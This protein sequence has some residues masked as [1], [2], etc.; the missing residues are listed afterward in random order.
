MG[1]T[2]DLIIVTKDELATLDP[3]SSDSFIRK[4]H[5]E[6]SLL[7][8]GLSDLGFNVAR[9]SWSDPEF[10]WSSTKAI[11]FRSTWD[12]FHRYDEWIDWLAKTGEVTTMINPHAI[13]EWNMDKHYLIDLK[14]KGIHIPDTIVFETGSVVNL[15]EAF[16][17]SGWTN[18]ILKPCIAGTARHTYKIVD[19]V[20]PEL[21][22]TF[23]ELI[24]KEAM[25]L[26]PFINSVVTK[27]E[28]SLMVMGGQYTH[29]VIKKPKD[30]DFRVQDDFGG[31]VEIYEPS[32]EEI[33]FAEHVVATCDPQPTYARVDVV[34]DNK[35]KLAL[36]ELELIEPEV[37]FRLFP[38]AANVLVEAVAKKLA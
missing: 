7:A 9:K 38:D 2:F 15:A 5:R 33:A 24:K 10:D 11:L 17:S 12:Y 1:K 4:V 6:E 36:M 13:I 37:W 27:G 8:D 3:D 26:Q 32:P 34:T 19:G 18:A 22:A 28:I 31:S 25:M 16:R 21:E 20:S 23:Q 14:H 35:N 30:G 29:A